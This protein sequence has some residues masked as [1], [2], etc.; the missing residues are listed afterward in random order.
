MVRRNTRLI[1]V[2]ALIWIAGVIIYVYRDRGTGS[3]AD[4]KSV[5]KGLILKNFIPGGTVSKNLFFM[6]FHHHFDSDCDIHSVKP[7]FPF[8]SL[9]FHL[10]AL[11]CPILSCLVM[12][13]LVW[14]ASFYS[15]VLSFGLF[16]KFPSNLS[17]LFFVNTLSLSSL[18]LIHSL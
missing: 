12:S 9:I 2:L 14:S 16:L 1:F 18:S 17:T 5:N 6:L 7:T 11:S 13:C 4:N 15:H 3:D 10:V 8:F